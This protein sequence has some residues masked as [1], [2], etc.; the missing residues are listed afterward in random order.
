MNLLRG[1]VACPPTHVRPQQAAK[2]QALDAEDTAPDSG[3]DG[4]GWGAA[5]APPPAPPGNAFAAADVAAAAA[6]SAFAAGASRRD[7]FMTGA[8]AAAAAA[9]NNDAAMNATPVG[10]MLSILAAS[11]HTAAPADNMAASGRM[12]RASVTLEHTDAIRKALA[13]VLKQGNGGGGGAAAATGVAAAADALG[14]AGAPGPA[15]NSGMM[16]ST[17]GVSPQTSVTGRQPGPSASSPVASRVL[18]RISDSDAGDVIVGSGELP[19][20]AT[21]GCLGATT[22]SGYTKTAAAAAAAAAAGGGAASVTEK[23]SGF[24]A[25]LTARTVSRTSVLPDRSP[26]STATG[27]ARPEP[28]GAAAGAGA[29][30][31]SPA[32]AAAAATATALLAGVRAGSAPASP[33]SQRSAKR[34]HT[35]LG[36]MPSRL[37][38]VTTPAGAAPLSVYSN[39]TFAPDGPT[40]GTERRSGSGSSSARTSRMSGNAASTLLRVGAPA[41]PPTGLH[42]LSGSGGPAAPASPSGA[43][44]AP[45]KRGTTLRNLAS[46]FFGGGRL[47]GNG[48]PSES[49][50]RA[51]PLSAPTDVGA[52]F[53][54]A[55]P[56]ASARLGLVSPPSRTRGALTRSAV[57]MKEVFGRSRGAMTPPAASEAKS[58]SASY[59]W[60]QAP[61][62]P[63]MATGAAAGAAGPQ[64]TPVRGMRVA[65][66]SSADG[67]GA[68]AGVGREGGSGTAV[69][70][71]HSL[72]GTASATRTFGLGLEP[73]HT[74]LEL[75]VDIGASDGPASGMVAAAGSITSGG[76]G[77]AAAAAAAAIAGAPKW[78]AVR[79]GDVAG[80]RTNTL[81]AG[82]QARS[83]P[84]RRAT[85]H[86]GRTGGGSTGGAAGS[87]PGSPRA[88]AA[89]TSTGYPLLPS[90]SA[91]LQPPPPAL[92]SASPTAGDGGT[93]GGG[94]GGGGLEGKSAIGRML[95]SGSPSGVVSPGSATR[96]GLVVMPTRGYSGSGLIPI[97][98]APAS[99]SRSPAGGSG[100]GSLGGALGSAAASAMATTSAAAVASR[101]SPNA[102]GGRQGVDRSGS[103]GPAAAAAK[104]A[105]GSSGARRQQVL[106]PLGR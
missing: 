78:L 91:A 50:A 105:P 36:H 8:A 106:S 38:L 5:A 41:T 52:G 66:V 25:R 97:S 60:Q 40:D 23:R 14:S 35:D 49:A 80:G 75:D 15:V 43:A 63:S 31:I 44:A 61:S 94:T 54:P 81:A 51:P 16:I 77:S 89:I 2:R 45:V 26:S 90:R 58:G 99:R 3:G 103:P 72:R 73:D 10:G 19:N 104:G 86:A 9:P 102:S 93:G 37:Q 68:G 65:F 74:D 67:P 88:A 84:Q 100:G 1:A 42:R 62:S 87:A 95:A 96:S 57:S 6:A 85:F 59:P 20:L 22:S 46:A 56:G 32:A 7:S 28:E 12:R 48:A 98:T 21:G 82:Q 24:L 34:S 39:L 76:N 29:D 17:S 4:S 33:A 70:R 47:S 55:S 13:D 69:P 83:M 53:A 11:R 92:P 30:R 79:A 101:A 64:M 27:F 71:S 18:G